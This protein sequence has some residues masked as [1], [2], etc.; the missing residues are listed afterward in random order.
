MELELVPLVLAGLVGLVGLALVADGWL[1]DAADR[2]AERRRHARAERHHGGEVAVGFGLLCAAAALAG[3]DTWRYATLAVIAAA[4]LVLG[5]A[6][7]NARYL[8]ERLS[9]RGAARRG[10]DGE[11]RRV[12]SGVPPGAVERRPHDR[13]V[14]D[15]RDGPA[16][17]GAGPG[18][19]PPAT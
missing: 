16:P 18:A 4:V 1:P 7:L 19:D 17:A 3:R 8:R 15:R 13:R 14:A 2:V 6:L 9:N 11:R 10:R 5:G 12:G